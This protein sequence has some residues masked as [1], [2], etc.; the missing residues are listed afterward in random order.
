MKKPRAVLL[1][2]GSN[3]GVSSEDY[4]VLVDWWF[5]HSGWEGD[6]DIGY[7][8]D[9]DGDG[10]ASLLTI[11]IDR[12]NELRGKLSK[13]YGT[14]YVL[15]LPDASS[16]EFAAAGSSDLAQWKRMFR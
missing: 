11:N 4:G 1:N 14:I 15:A 7:L 9:L 2:E 13:R 6:G 5:D 3:N 16:V 8:E 10:P 12:H